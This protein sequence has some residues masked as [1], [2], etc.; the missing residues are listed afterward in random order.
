MRCRPCRLGPEAIG[1]RGGPHSYLVSADSALE[2]IQPAGDAV[3]LENGK[4]RSFK[5]AVLTDCENALRLDMRG[6]GSL[7]VKAGAADEV[8]EITPGDGGFRTF[9]ISGE[10]GP[11]AVEIVPDGAIELVTAKRL[12]ECDRGRQMYALD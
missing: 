4:T 9:S 1:A 7:A 11:L 5:V 8:F 3:S 12:S 2:P 10:N 6:S